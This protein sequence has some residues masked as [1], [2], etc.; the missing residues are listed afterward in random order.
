ML[1]MYVLPCDDMN[2]ADK[3]RLEESFNFTDMDGIEA[4]LPCEVIHLDHRRLCSVDRGRNPWYGYIIAHEWFSEGLSFALTTYLQSKHFDLYV[5]SK[6]VVERRGA[7]RQTRWFVE[8]RIFRSHV[9]F[10]DSPERVPVDVGNLRY[11]RVL[12]G[13]IY[14][15]ER[16]IQ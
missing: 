3:K 1:T 9:I 14:E 11:E 2:Q 4:R 13:W 8:S 6:K 15:P 16:I 5:L 12:D 7:N 10:P